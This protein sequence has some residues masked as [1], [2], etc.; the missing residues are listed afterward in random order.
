MIN[1]EWDYC[2]KCDKHVRT[3]Y[4]SFSTVGQYGAVVYA[5]EYCLECGHM[6][7]EKLLDQ[8]I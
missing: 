2:P 8:D 1:E 6:I 3:D 5:R 4:E 7:R